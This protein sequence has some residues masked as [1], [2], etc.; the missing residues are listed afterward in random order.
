MTTVFIIKN[1][2]QQ[3]EK[4]DWADFQLYDSIIVRL[5]IIS[6]SSSITCWR[7]VMNGHNLI[8]SCK[9]WLLIDS[10]FNK[11]RFTRVNNDCSWDWHE[12]LKLY[13]QST[14]KPYGNHDEIWG[15]QHLYISVNKCAKRS[16][17]A[18]VSCLYLWYVLWCSLLPCIH[19]IGTFRDSAPANT[20]F[21]PA[22]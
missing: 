20:A 5:L 6:S 14:T 18:K 19:S 21:W 8:G 9:T 15:S 11:D 10:L 16:F 22:K 17:L 1:Q 13:W 4:P 2:S 3:L 7:D 12:C